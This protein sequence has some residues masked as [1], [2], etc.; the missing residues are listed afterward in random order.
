MC[1]WMCMRMCHG[2]GYVQCLDICFSCRLGVALHNIANKP[3]D[4]INTFKSVL[5]F[6]T[7]DHLVRK[8]FVI[9]Y[10]TY[11]YYLSPWTSCVSYLLVFMPTHT[12]RTVHVFGV[13]TCLCAYSC[14]AHH[15]YTVYCYETASTTCPAAVLLRWGLW[16]R[17][18]R[19][20]W[21]A[22]RGE[23][24]SFFTSFFISS[25]SL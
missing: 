23:L 25:L 18:A 4:A 12:S 22:P 7:G 21:A 19:A 20:H 1:M 3:K 24:A 6:D 16:P 14:M 11:L 13:F 15:I 9:E 2:C 8:H 17:S 5:A 10:L